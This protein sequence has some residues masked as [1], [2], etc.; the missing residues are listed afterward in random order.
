MSIPIGVR[1]RVCVCVCRSSILSSRM[2][3]TCSYHRSN[4]NSAKHRTE[5]SSEHVSQQKLKNVLVVMDLGLEGVGKNV[6]MSF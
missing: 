6:N 5:V 3:N 1:V 4:H 2:T